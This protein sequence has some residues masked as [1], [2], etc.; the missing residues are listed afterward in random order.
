MYN[1]Y[2]QGLML[3]KHI[4]PP[5]IYSSLQRIRADLIKAQSQGH[6]PL[7]GVKEERT[8]AEWSLLVWNV[9]GS[10]MEGL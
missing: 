3:L 5:R 7:A 9:A 6:A 1:F 10:K 4:A 8:G 2:T